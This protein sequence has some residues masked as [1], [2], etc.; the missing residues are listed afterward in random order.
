VIDGRRLER[1]K[2]LQAAANDASRSV[3]HLHVVL[4]VLLTYVAINV[5]STTDEQLVRGLQ[6]AL[7]LLDFK[8][9]I[10]GFYVA[11]PW[12]LVV[13][14]FYLLLHLNV[15]ASKVSAVDAEINALHSERE[16]RTQRE[17][18]NVFVFVQALIGQQHRFLTRM[19]LQIATWGSVWVLPALLLL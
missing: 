12:L 9:S 15:L 5:W 17:L 10:W 18:L 4:I 6:I 2:K 1:L 13:F 3:Q 11:V 19:L 7:P 14:H 16:R 8:V